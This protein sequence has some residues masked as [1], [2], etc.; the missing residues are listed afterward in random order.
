[1]PRA[2]LIATGAASTAA[3]AL[4]T[5]LEIQHHRHHQQRQGC[6]RRQR[7]P[8]LQQGIGDQLRAARG[9]Q[10]LATGSIAAT[11]TITGMSMLS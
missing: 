1:M 4:L 2:R 11:S 9:F 10:R 3:A 6:R 8:Q 7:L 5:T